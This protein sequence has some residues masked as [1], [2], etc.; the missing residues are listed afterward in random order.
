MIILCSVCIYTY[1]H[2]PA[3]HLHCTEMLRSYLLYLSF[4]IIRF[5][6]LLLISDSQCFHWCSPK[7]QNICKIQ[8]R[9]S[10]QP[11]RQASL[12]LKTINKVLH[13]RSTGCLWDCP[14]T[15]LLRDMLEI[16][17]GSGHL[18]CLQVTKGLNSQWQ[19][20]KKIK[21]KPFVFWLQCPELFILNS[22]S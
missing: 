4:P 11:L 9:E 16:I 10:L 6:P 5:F 21:N 17:L 22:C 15:T 12:Y 18:M 13:H 2:F 7:A 14:G 8:W 20:K 3:F 19:D 1:T